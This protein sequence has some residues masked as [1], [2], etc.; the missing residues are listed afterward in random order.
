MRSWRRRTA[1]RAGRR[2]TSRRG[3]SGT[4]E[5]WNAA[6]GHPNFLRKA[7]MPPERPGSRP[8]RHPPR[9]LANSRSARRV[10]AAPGLWRTHRRSVQLNGGRRLLKRRA[11][12]DREGRL[13]RTR[14]ETVC[15]ENSAILTVAEACHGTTARFAVPRGPAGCLGRI[16]R[17]SKKFGWPLPHF[18]LFR[19]PGIPRRLVLR[20]PGRHAVRPDH[21]HPRSTARSRWM[22][23]GP[24]PLHGS[25]PYPRRSRLDRRQNGSSAV[26]SSRSTR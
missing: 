7:P 8:P 16:R 25:G 18:H 22:R 24:P 19:V 3:V 17:C 26:F 5:R 9:D 15:A 13:W 21:D 6:G 20:R 11:A 23:H 14:Q 4:G 2:G 10:D 1:W 12:G